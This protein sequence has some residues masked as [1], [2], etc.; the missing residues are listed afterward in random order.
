M[1]LYAV[2]RNIKNRLAYGRHAPWHSQRI[3]VDATRCTHHLPPG[4][5]PYSYMPRRLSGIVVGG[6]WDRRVKPIDQSPKVGFC[7]LHW[8]SGISWEETGCY[9]YSMAIIEKEGVLDGM[10][11]LDEVK[12]RYIRLDEIFERVKKERRL[13]NASELGTARGKNREDHGIM[14]HL[15]RK[16][17]PVFGDSGCHRMAMAVVLG[18]TCIPAKVGIVHEEFIPG[19]IERIKNDAF[20]KSYDNP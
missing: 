11:S 4:E 17:N 5:R 19:W 3:Y 6:D 1:R 8:R 14:I 2:L 18:L 13:L 7:L 9:E 20:A 16:G 10:R 12:E 15:D